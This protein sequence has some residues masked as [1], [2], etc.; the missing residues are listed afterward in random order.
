VLVSSRSEAGY[1]R[2]LAGAPVRGFLAKSELTGE[3][4]ATMLR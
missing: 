1:R 3:S 4:L 2:R